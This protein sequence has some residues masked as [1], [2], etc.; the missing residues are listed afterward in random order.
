MKTTKLVIGV[1]SIILSLLLLFQSS[2]AELV[3]DIEN[4]AETD[5]ITGMLLAFSLLVA[6]IVAITTKNSSG[7]GNFIAAGFY[8]AGGYGNL[9]IWTVL[10]IIF[11]AVF[12]IGDP[13]IRKNNQNTN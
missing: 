5:R 1:I 3:N 4:K 9:Y 12:V 6:G 13:K 2:I 11:G 10:S 8:I 7:N